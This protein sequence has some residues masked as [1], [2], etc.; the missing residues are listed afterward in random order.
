MNFIEISIKKS[1][2][3]TNI[4]RN[5]ERKTSQTHKTGNEYFIRTQ[6]DERTYTHTQ[7]EMNRCIRTGTHTHT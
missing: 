6:R 3:A 7:I 2:V 4:K 1:L 5:S